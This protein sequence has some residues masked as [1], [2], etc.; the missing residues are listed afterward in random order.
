M[1]PLISTVAV[2]FPRPIGAVVRQIPLLRDGD[3]YALRQ[4][5]E[6]FIHSDTAPPAI[7]ALRH[8]FSTLHAYGSASRRDTD[9]L[10][11]SVDQLPH[12]T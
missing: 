12:M 1:D 2:R 5:V 4:S 8:C 10:A 3:A 6:V 9:R 7:A 11:D